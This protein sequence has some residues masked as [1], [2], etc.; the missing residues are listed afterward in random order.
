MD[1]KARKRRVILLGGAGL[2]G[3]LF[4]GSAA[5][6]KKAPKKNVKYQDKPNGKEKCA[7]CMHFIKAKDGKGMGE[8]KIIEGP[9]SPNGWCA[10]WEVPPK[11]K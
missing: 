5:A 2:I 10:E 9:I 7:D 1:Q 4:L 6:Q 8:C 11:K 3:T